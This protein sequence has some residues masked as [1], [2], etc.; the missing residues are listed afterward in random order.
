MTALLLAL[1][2][3]TFVSLGL[4]D[5]L[6]GSAWPT[7]QGYFDVPSSWAGY[8]SMT[9]TCMTVVSSLLAPGLLARFHTK[10]IVIISIGLT[11]AG[12]LGFSL[13]ASYWQ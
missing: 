7:M 2:Y 1:I 9:I 3:L 5:S 8:I 12:L 11:V 13:A 10:Y 4:P 6:L